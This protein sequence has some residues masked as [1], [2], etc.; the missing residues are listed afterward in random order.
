MTIRIAIT[1]EN[2]PPT[3]KRYFRKP[4]RAIASLSDEEIVRW[5]ANV[6]APVMAFDSEKEGPK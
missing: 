1:E 5:A 2:Q 3:W 4:Y 6:D